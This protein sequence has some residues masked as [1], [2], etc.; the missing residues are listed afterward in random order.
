MLMGFITVMGLELELV[1]LSI[2]LGLS[3]ESSL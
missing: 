2:G 1:S 3:L